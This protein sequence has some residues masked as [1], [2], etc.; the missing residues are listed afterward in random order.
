MEVGRGEEVEVG[1]GGGGRKRGG[2]GG[3]KR[4]RVKSPVTMQKGRGQYLI[5]NRITECL[6]QASDADKESY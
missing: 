3:R 6:M 2:G 4:G 5:V 1:G